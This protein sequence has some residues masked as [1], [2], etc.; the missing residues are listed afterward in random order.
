MN[1][2]EPD[3]ALDSV[4][5]NTVDKANDTNGHPS[6]DSDD[7]IDAENSNVDEPD[8]IHD[9]SKTN[10]ANN[11]QTES[12]VDDDLEQN[13][14]SANINQG[15][16]KETVSDDVEMKKADKTN[17]AFDHVNTD[18]DDRIDEENTIIDQGRD[19]SIQ[20]NVSPIQMN[21]TIE[22]GS[23]NIGEQNIVEGGLTFMQEQLTSDF[24]N[25]EDQAWNH[26]E[27]EDEDY[28]IGG[29]SDSSSKL[30]Q[31]KVEYDS[32]DLSIKLSTKHI[33]EKSKKK[34]TII[35]FDEDSDDKS[36]G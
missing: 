33:K 16:Q 34:F 3:H 24:N 11:E 36:E 21:T 18:C 8:I 30:N 35:P 9:S 29:S 32:S 23:V 1:V 20:D 14:V 15:L 13:D 7:R 4:K 6:Q 26:D 19:L 22:G 10:D 12:I 17:G 25:N 28:G 2:D 5:V 27:V 31:E